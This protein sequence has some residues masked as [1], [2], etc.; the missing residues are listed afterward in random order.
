MNDPRDGSG[1]EGSAQDRDLQAL[2]DALAEEDRGHTPEFGQMLD[3]AKDAAEASE[4]EAGRDQGRRQ[5]STVWWRAIP[6]GA[7]L[8][9]AGIGAIALMGGPASEEAA[10]QEAV[11][12]ASS[13][14]MFA[15]LTGP[16]D[17]FLETPGWT[18]LN[19]GNPLGGAAS[20]LSDLLDLG[21]GFND[22]RNQS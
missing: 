20:G 11:S 9:A 6:A 12:W 2:F 17:V 15:S 7:V 8:A 14:P 1:R 3:R 21:T 4:S 18:L 22:E 19:T 5:Q 13:D 16:S 10:F